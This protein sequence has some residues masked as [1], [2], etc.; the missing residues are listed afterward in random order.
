MLAFLFEAGATPLDVRGG[1]RSCER[2]GATEPGAVTPLAAAMAT[3]TAAHLREEGEEDLAGLLHDRVGWKVPSLCPLLAGFVS[4]GCSSV[5]SLAPV[6][7]PA[8]PAASHGRSEIQLGSKMQSAF[9][10]SSVP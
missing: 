9:Q 10:P 4:H 1:S 3:P 7:C 8:R 5:G 6:W 2:W